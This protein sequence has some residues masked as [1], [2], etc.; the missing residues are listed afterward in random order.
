MWLQF[1]TGT[2]QSL[3]LHRRTE[4]TLY[5]GVLL[6]MR[7]DVSQCPCGMTK[8][9]RCHQEMWLDSP[10]GT[11]WTCVSVSSGWIHFAVPAHRRTKVYMDS[12]ILYVA[13]GTIE[14]LTTFSMLFSEVPHMS[15]VR[16]HAP[17]PDAPSM[18]VRDC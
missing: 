4:G 7:P 15:R 12:L 8:A 10:E 16:W 3:M 11:Q 13:Y 5:T 6:L 1:L 18:L 9:R 14:I 17:N 2:H